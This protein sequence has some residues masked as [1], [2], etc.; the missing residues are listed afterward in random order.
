M[1]KSDR[2]RTMTHASAGAWVCG[3]TGRELDHKTAHIPD[4]EAVAEFTFV[5]VARKRG[6]RAI[7]GVPLLRGD[8]LIGSAARHA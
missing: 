4:F 2:D 3:R 7:L 6:V 5:D 8:T 1:R